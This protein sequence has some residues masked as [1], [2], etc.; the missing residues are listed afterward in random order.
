M[1][2]ITVAQLVV[3]LSNAIYLATLTWGKF[4][5]F[6]LSDRWTGRESEEH[7]DVEVWSVGW[8]GETR[9]CDG[10]QNGGGT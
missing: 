2:F 9:K 6:L 1:P 5:L 7:A 8:S 3:S 4:T 10:E